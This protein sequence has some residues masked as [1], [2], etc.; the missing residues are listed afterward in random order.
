[1]L[2]PKNEKTIAGL[3]L[4]VERLER[5]VFSNQSVK[6]KPADKQNFQGATG[7]LRYLISK[8]FFDRKHNFGEIKKGLADNNYHYSNQAV[9]TPLNNLSKAGGP[10][11]SLKEKG[12]KV[13]AKRK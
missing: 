4:R 5:T 8:G 11:V 13:Y 10:L 7:G 6:S 3:I 9:Q 2:T 1:M 12:K